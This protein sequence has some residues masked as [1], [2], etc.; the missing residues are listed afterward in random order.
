MFESVTLSELRVFSASTNQGN[1][2]SIKNTPNPNMISHILWV[3][4]NP[5]NLWKLMFLVSNCW[6]AH[7]LVVLVVIHFSESVVRSHHWRLI[8]ELLKIN[9]LNQ[10]GYLVVVVSVAQIVLS[11]NEEPTVPSR[12]L[13]GG[14]M[15]SHLQRREDRNM[16]FNFRKCLQ[17]CLPQHFHNNRR[18]LFSL[19][20]N[21]LRCRN[22]RLLLNDRWLLEWLGI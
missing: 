17:R 1:K 13:N 21:H 12:F 20:L 10:I 8:E 5:V 18:F 3:F 15:L 22:F 9:H 6:S 14:V 2:F 11:V 16:L 7:N 4:S 19:T